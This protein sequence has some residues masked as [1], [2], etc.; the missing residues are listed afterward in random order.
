MRRLGRCEGEAD[1]ERNSPGLRRHFGREGFEGGGF[2][3]RS[4][5]G[6]I[7]PLKGA[8]F[9]QFNF[10]HHSGFGDDHSQ[11]NRSLLA[12]GPRGRRVSLPD[13]DRI[14]DVGEVAFRFV[15]GRA[16]A[17]KSFEIR[18][19]GVLRLGAASRPSEI[20]G[21]R[22]MPSLFGQ[23]SGGQAS[24]GGI[25]RRRDRFCRFWGR[26][27]SSSCSSD[28]RARRASGSIHPSQVFNLDRLGAL[29]TDCKVEADEGDGMQNEADENR[30]AQEKSL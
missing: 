26:L 8:R 15:Q 28:F 21:S 7:Q 25:F 1:R 24:G 22:G 13:C 10:F 30:A 11:A 17:W 3:H 20:W 14:A 5:G 23:A 27:R 12:Q 6:V 19:T 4:Y 2:G 18:F 16:A 29:S 9:E